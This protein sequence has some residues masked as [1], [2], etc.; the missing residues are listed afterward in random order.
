MPLLEAFAAGTPVLC[1]NTTSLPE[2]GGDAVLSCDPTDV[3]AMS[4]LMS[5][6]VENRRLV[7]QLIRRGKRRLQEYCWEHSADNLMAAFE[8]VVS[9][10][11]SLSQE[12]TDLTDVMH[13]KETHNMA[14]EQSEPVHQDD[15]VWTDNWIGAT[16]RVRL[17]DN[18]VG[19]HIHLSGVATEAM[20]LT[21]AV[22]D[23]P[24][25][26]FPLLGQRVE[27]IA[28]QVEPGSGRTVTL[29]FSKHMVDSV[30]RRL[31]FRV[32]G[33]NLFREQD[34]KDLLYNGEKHSRARISGNGE[35][36]MR[37]VVVIS[38]V[39]VALI[40]AGLTAAAQ[41]KP[42][43]PEVKVK[44]KPVNYEAILNDRLSKGVAP[45]KNAVVLIW[46]AIGP[47]PAEKLPP[48]YFKR[49][50][51]D[52]PPEDS[53]YY[54]TSS[55]YLRTLTKLD[56]DERNRVLIEEDW[57]RKRPWTERDCPHT[58]AWLNL[59]EKPLALAI[60][61][62]QR[63]DYYNPQVTHPENGR[64][65]LLIGA[66]LPTVQP[67]R[68]MAQAFACRAMRSVNAGKYDAA[69]RDLLAC[70]RLGRTGWPR[71]HADRGP[72]RLCD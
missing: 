15:N 7:R 69:W 24:I 42:A 35:P 1:S 39:F 21:V 58:A 47:A 22:N 61:A 71:R 2:V 12:D 46:K 48:A 13:A 4:S 41:E 9:R 59:N 53:N 20:E 62:I 37:R 27:E 50:G 33:S 72:H 11:G 45:E 65:G 68:D 17:P 30:G 44:D 40:I 55:K 19:D 32:H 63:P 29:H 70:H 26:V 56:H 28:F 67:C 54:V 52:K 6:I 51:I 49:L 3:E 66:F 34:L 25:E 31:S 64:P 23:T 38:G 18:P 57:A 60:E 8:R 5:R 36:P 16:C 43:V 10:T 14:G